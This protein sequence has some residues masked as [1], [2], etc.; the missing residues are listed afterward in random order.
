MS[1]MFVQK[2]KKSKF[3]NENVKEVSE[4]KEKVTFVMMH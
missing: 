2:Q 3:S 4:I 1:K